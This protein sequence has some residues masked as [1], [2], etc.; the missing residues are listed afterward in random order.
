MM[1]TARPKVTV[2]SELRRLLAEYGI[3]PSKR[4]GQSFL[5][6]AN[7]VANI[8]AAA[9][10][11]GD[12]KVFEV[13]PGA[14]ALTVALAE[15]AGTVVALELDRRLVGLLRGRLGEARNVRIEQ[16]DIL[17]VDLR[18]LL[19]GGIWKLVA[20]LPYSVIGPAI[21]RLTQQRPMF[22]LMVLMVQ[23]EVAQRLA[24]PPGGRQ[25]GVLSV[26]V[27]AQMRVEMIARVGRT[28]F[29]PQ[30]QVDS[31]LVR[32]TPLDKPAVA[33][34]IEPVF[35]G[36]VRAVFRQRRKMLANSLAGAAELGLGRDAAKHALAAAGIEGARRAESLSIEE[37]TR[38]ARAVAAETEAT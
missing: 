38:L 7:I 6:D 34:D 17:K 4:L 10:I 21:A 16:G 23:R 12:D 22:S 33:A 1:A 5:V 28:C 36:V 37:F 11:G 14:G 9:D 2:P 30:P 32:L 19:G 26:L 13:G 25:Y 29:Y 18:A 35:A 8:L 20:N 31:S 24:A 3:R 15:R 27:Q